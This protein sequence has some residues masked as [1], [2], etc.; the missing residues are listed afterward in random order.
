MAQNSTNS[1]N[2]NYI[3]IS[4]LK[5]ASEFVSASASLSP[6]VSTTVSIDSSNGSRRDSIEDI[7]AELLNLKI[8][9]NHPKKKKKK[10]NKLILNIENIGRIAAAGFLPV[11]NHLVNNVRRP[12]VIL[13]KDTYKNMCGDLGGKVSNQDDKM[14]HYR[15]DIP[16]AMREGHEESAEL[17]DFTNSDHFASGFGNLAPFI[18]TATGF[19]HSFVFAISETGDTL[20]NSDFLVNRAQLESEG[21]APVYLEMSSIVKFYIDDLQNAIKSSPYKAETICMDINGNL[22]TIHMRTKMIIRDAIK[23]KLI[24]KALKNPIVF[25]KSFDEKR[26]LHRLQSVKRL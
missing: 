13:F 10:Q 15:P 9:N 20:D 14:D 21:A 4:E 1:M 24:A 6:S 3:N 18:R 7:E 5:T 2:Y 19:F 8:Q 26:K 12:V 23:Y 25:K 17:L 16:C 11:E 22:Q